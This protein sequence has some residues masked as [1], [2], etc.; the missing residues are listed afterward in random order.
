MWVVDLFKI[1]IH[2]YVLL[3]HPHSILIQIVT[4]FE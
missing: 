3:F 4:A 2:R 1:V